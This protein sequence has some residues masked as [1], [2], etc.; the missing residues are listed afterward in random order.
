M[1]QTNETQEEM[2][3]LK[4]TVKELEELNDIIANRFIFNGM[5]YTPKPLLLTSTERK[6]LIERV[7]KSKEYNLDTY[8][9]IVGSQQYLDCIKILIAE[10]ENDD[11]MQL[12]AAAK[13][14][15]KDKNVSQKV[16]KDDS[17]YKD[18][19]LTLN[20]VAVLSA[21]MYEK[22]QEEDLVSGG[23]HDLVI[24]PER[25]KYLMML[26]E[27]APSDIDQ[28]YFS[29]ETV[30]TEIKFPV[31][32]TDENAKILSKMIDEEIAKEAS[33]LK[34]SEAAEDD[35]EVG[36]YSV[37][38]K[39][40]VGIPVRTVAYWGSIMWTVMFQ[41]GTVFKNKDIK[42]IKKLDV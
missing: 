17:T 39:N 40:S 28:A 26:I 42:I 33:N 37:V 11:M 35:L 30:D 12:E 38:V 23:I 15:A 9:E 19:L 24:T 7:L 2:R 14:I 27:N 34:E 29:N 10:S 4:L 41:E 36:Y 3:C 21:L 32:I 20:Q 8:S 1:T 16:K 22:K 25:E 6:R 31:V 18:V 13:A 5:A